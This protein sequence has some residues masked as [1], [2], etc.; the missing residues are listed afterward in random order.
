M[1]VIA[2]GQSYDLAKMSIGTV[3]AAVVMFGVLLYFSIHIS[4][5]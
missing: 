3:A 4:Y 5:G 1:N 2:I